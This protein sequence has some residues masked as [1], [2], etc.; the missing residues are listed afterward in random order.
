MLHTCQSHGSKNRLHPRLN[1]RVASFENCDKSIHIRVVAVECIHDLLLVDRQDGG[2]M[3]VGAAG[4]RLRNRMSQSAAAD[5]A[6][7]IWDG[8]EESIPWQQQSHL[9]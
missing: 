2:G 3:A 5:L 1:F 8:T 9:R 4:C 7:C 6:G